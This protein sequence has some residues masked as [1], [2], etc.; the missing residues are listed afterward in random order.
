MTTYLECTLPPLSCVHRYKKQWAM[1]GW[2]QV[3]SAYHSF[4]IGR[5]HIVG[6][7]T[8]ALY[9]GAI[10]PTKEGMLRWLAQD[11]AKANEPTSRQQRP[12]VIVHFHRPAYSTG[13][14]DATPFE[15]FE[16]LMEQHSVD[17]VFAGHVHNQERT[18]P[19]FNRTLMPGKDPSRPY[20]NSRAPVYVVSGNPGNA[21]ETNYFNREFE[22]WTGWRSYTFGYSHLTLLNQTAIEVEFFSTNLA[23]VTDTF[24]LSKDVSCVFGASCT[25]PQPLAGGVNGPRGTVS[26]TPAVAPRTDL[27]ELQLRWIEEQAKLAGPVPQAQRDALVELFKATNGTGWRRHDGWLS[28]DPCTSPGWYGVSCLRVTER[29]L[30]DLWNSSTG[31]AGGVTALHLASNRL[32]GQI[33]A[34]LGPALAPSLQLLDLSSNR[35]TGSLPSSLFAMPRLHTLFVEPETNKTRHRLQGSLPASIGEESG[36]PSL[37]FLALS[38]NM[39]TGSIPASLGSLSCHD[40]HAS[41]TEVGCIIWMIGNELTGP[42]PRA[43]CKA[44]YNEV[45]VSENNLTCPIPCLHLGYGNFDHCAEKCVPC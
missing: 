35:L 39:L 11:L 37:R 2:E 20:H 19:V 15:V 1:P 38:R 29:A 33:P 45:Y 10:G 21:E 42:I 17:L 27:R 24:V 16:P 41:P 18:F 22:E 6:I 30:P 43:M 13:N 44:T 14:T 40:I 9:G 23:R 32:A 12:W 36:L 28:G 7:N 34:A 4:N 8:E 31:S 5:A 3:S 25:D 26:A